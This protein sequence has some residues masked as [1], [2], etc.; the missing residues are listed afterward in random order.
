MRRK[1]ILLLSSAY[2]GLTQRV[3]CELLSQ[4]YNVKALV[5]SSEEVMKQGVETFKPDLILC[6][7]LKIAVP[8]SIWQNRKT[9]ILHPGIKGD[10]GPSS[11]DWCLEENNKQ[12]GVTVLE[13]DYEMDAGAIY[14]TR[15]F[16][17]ESKRKS[18]LYNS[19]ISYYGT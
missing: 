13:A 6:P 14:E 19:E 12:W 10:R 16:N 18:T 11:I 1:N 7:M 17:F 3:Q 5:A 8:D 4:R 9:L 15:N 2:N